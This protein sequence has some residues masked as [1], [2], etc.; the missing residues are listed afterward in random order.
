VV[1]APGETLTFRCS[2]IGKFKLEGD[3]QEAA[4]L[5]RTFMQ[6]GDLE[7]ISNTKVTLQ[8]RNTQWDM[9]KLI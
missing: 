9:T 4:E 8:C 7:N 6:L 3:R 5:Q 2:D 1:L